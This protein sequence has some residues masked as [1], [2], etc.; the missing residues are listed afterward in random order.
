MSGSKID[1]TAAKDFAIALEFANRTHNVIL[2]RF[3]DPNIL[4][5]VHTVLVFIHHI[6]FYPE[7]IA[8]LAPSF[9]WKLMSLVLNTLLGSFQSYARI[10]SKNFPQPEE[11]GPPRPLPEDYAMRGLLWADNYYPT[12]WFTNDKI[13]DN[14]KG[15]EAASM[16][17]ERKIRALYLGYCIARDK[18]WLLYDSEAHHFSVSP[19]FDIELDPALIASVKD[20]GDL[21]DAIH[22]VAVKKHNFGTEIGEGNS[23]DQGN[24]RTREAFFS[25]V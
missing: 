2:R 6:T 21:P 23:D 17:E 8:R 4:T 1:E 19:Q 11:D 7:A 25:Q 22:S 24:H 9:P 5:Y 3:G 20:C 14:E 12:G 18:P 13:E 16:G 10:E 15:L